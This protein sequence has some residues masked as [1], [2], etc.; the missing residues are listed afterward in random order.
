MAE[1]FDLKALEKR[2][3]GA[4]ASLK[5][6]FGGLRTGRA[7]VHLLDTVQVSAY[8]SMM[9]LNQV[10]SV[11]APE[12]RMLAVNVWDKSMVGATDRAIRESPLGLNPIMD[13]QT[14]RIPIPPLSE[15]RR[16]EL[17]K[18]AG[19]FSEAAKIAVRNVRRDGMDLLK[20]LEK[21]GQINED[22]LK[23][24]EKDIQ[25]ITDA[26]VSGIDDALG[27]KQDEIMQV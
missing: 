8:G 9:P 18:L 27:A 6:E 12:A 24:R 26:A 25:K 3:D 17:A 23:G 21:A 16:R 20:R 1:Q 22:Q 15:E 7:S 2:M 19:K 10:A 14:L 4:I 13:G 5:T 11:S